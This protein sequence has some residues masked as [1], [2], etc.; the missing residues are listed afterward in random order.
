[1]VER[2][3]RELRRRDKVIGIYPNDASAMRL[4]S[5]Q[6]VEQDEAWSTRQ[7]YLDME[8]YWRWTKQREPIS[9]SHD[10]EA[11]AAE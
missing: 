3:N 2:L 1:M 6:L 5:I 9:S 10:Q 4:M 11:A 7:A 8:E